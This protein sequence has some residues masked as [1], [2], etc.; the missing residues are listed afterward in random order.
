MPRCWL[1]KS[2]PSDYSFEQLQKDGTARWTGIRNFQ[3]RNNLK[4]M[5][6][7]DLVLY[8]HS[9]SEKQVVGIAQVVREAY[10]DAG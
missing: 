9:V 3:A 7:G 4:A 1:L 6:T 2:E 5:I 10:P 8:Y